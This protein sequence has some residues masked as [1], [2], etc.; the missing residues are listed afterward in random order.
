MRIEK[1]TISDIAKSDLESP[2]PAAAELS[3]SDLESDLESPDPGTIERLESGDEKGEA[4]GTE[5]P[6]D[7]VSPRGRRVGPA[8]ATT[9]ERE[10]D[11]AQNR[12]P[13]ES[14]ETKGG[15]PCISVE[16]KE[17]RIQSDATK[18]TDRTSLGEGFKIAVPA[19]VKET[20]SCAVSKK[21]DSGQYWASNED[22]AFIEALKSSENTGNTTVPK[23]EDRAE[24]LDGANKLKGSTADSGRKKDNAEI[25]AEKERAEN[26][27]DCVRGHG[28]KV[29][30]KRPEAGMTK[31]A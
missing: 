13:C 15:E 16:S 24:A 20:R 30:S 17:P 9:E 29:G 1:V 3:E 14:D 5:S 12:D 4:M 27:K 26:A 22:S 28:K 18:E 6:V 21:S 19:G 10:G 8:E 2:D 7:P 23:C 11:A 25:G 31:V